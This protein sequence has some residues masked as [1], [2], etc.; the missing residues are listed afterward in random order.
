[1]EWKGEIAMD[2]LIA[3]FMGSVTG[4]LIM[5]FVNSCSNTNKIYEAYMEGFIDG[6]NDK[7]GERYEV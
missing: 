2:V 4:C 1:M 5:A 7:N 6:K 3:F